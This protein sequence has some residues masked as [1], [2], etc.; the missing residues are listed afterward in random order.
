[1][2]FLSGGFFFS[3]GPLIKNV[4]KQNVK[5]T[6]DSFERAEKTVEHESD[7]DTN[8]SRRTRNSF[9]EFV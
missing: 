3:T 4:R 6:L 7:S 9:D 5:Q 1:M 8:N 2:T